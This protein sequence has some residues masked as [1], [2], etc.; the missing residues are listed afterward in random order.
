M[1]NFVGRS[2]CINLGKGDNF[3]FTCLFFSEEAE[4]YCNWWLEK[5]KRA[6]KL[7]TRK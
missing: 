3:A 2:P 4:S 5:I 6:G 1:E 7:F